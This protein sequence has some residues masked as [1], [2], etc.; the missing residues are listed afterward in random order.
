MFQPLRANTIWLMS[1]NVSGKFRK[2]KASR[3]QHFFK[4]MDSNPIIEKILE[5]H[6][7]LLKDD[8]KRY[9]NHVYRVFHLCLKLDMQTDNTDKYAIASAFHDIAIWTHNTF[10]YLQPSINQARDY[11]DLAGKPEWKDEISSMID[12]HHK[13]SRYFGPYEKTVETFRRA[14]WIDVTKGG[15]NFNINKKEITELQLKFPLL[16]FH[17][18]LLLQTVKNFFKNPL[19]PLPMFRK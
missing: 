10:D 1:K 5:A 3:N 6:R 18:F 11:L 19:N 9:Q 16:H 15:M 4:S 17:R 14:D 7:N 8:Y 12:M 13:I 2:L